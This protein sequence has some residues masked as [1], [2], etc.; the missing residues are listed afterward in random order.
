MRFG[1][2][3]DM[4][5]LKGTR[6]GAAFG[7]VYL[8]IVRLVLDKFK[9]SVIY[10][11]DTSGREIQSNIYSGLSLLSVIMA[12]KD[13]GS[14][15]LKKHGSKSSLMRRLAYQN[16]PSHAD[17]CPISPC[18]TPTNLNKLVNAVKSD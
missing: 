8:V 15:D 3:G 9:S 18:I 12:L 13:K 4:N 1:V 6:G 5:A 7:T 11:S 14:V 10:E 16:P 17:E 2:S